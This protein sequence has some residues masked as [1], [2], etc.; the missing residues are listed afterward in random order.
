MLIDRLTAVR[1]N[2]ELDATVYDRWS[3][4]LAQLA[5]VGTDIHLDL[6]ALRFIDSRSA[7]ELVRLADTVSKGQKLILCQP[8]YVLRRILGALWPQLPD[9][10]RIVP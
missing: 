1:V 6:S 8:P 5:D 7:S 3:A 4:E 2:G 9:S 10:M